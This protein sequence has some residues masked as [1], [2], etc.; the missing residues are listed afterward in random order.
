MASPNKSTAQKNN[1]TPAASEG[2]VS[3]TKPK[4]EASEKPEL[5]VL[6]AAYE[7]SNNEL[8]RHEKALEAAKAVRSARV[9]EISKHH[10]K[11]PFQ[12]N[13]QVLS[14]TTRTDKVGEG[15]D[16]KE[17]TRYYFKGN[18]KQVQVV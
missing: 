3:E 12:Y 6:F 16:A 9:E 14:V 18:K 4:A 11:G 7:E 5:K 10:G 17:V 13:G 8:V 2:P 1:T 15:E